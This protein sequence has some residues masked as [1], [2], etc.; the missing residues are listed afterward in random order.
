MAKADMLARI[1]G[2]PP[3]PLQSSVHHDHKSSAPATFVKMEAPTA[4]FGNDEGE[5]EEE[6]IDEGDPVVVPWG[7]NPSADEEEEEEEGVYSEDEVYL[8]PGKHARNAD[9]TPS[10]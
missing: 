2:G 7:A 4:V 5:E 1:G 10:A 8:E 9:L 6:F 3:V